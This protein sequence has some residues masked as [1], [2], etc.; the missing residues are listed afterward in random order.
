MVATGAKGVSRGKVEEKRERAK[1][2][3]VA[4][5]KRCPLRK[6]PSLSLKMLG[7]RR[8]KQWVRNPTALSKEG[9]KEM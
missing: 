4:R 5:G 8:K 1:R 6:I 2:A 9:K 7:N 3:I